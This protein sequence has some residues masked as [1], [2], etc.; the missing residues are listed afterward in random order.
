M[1]VLIVNPLDWVVSVVAGTVDASTVE[2]VTLTGVL[3]VPELTVITTS[4]LASEIAVPCPCAS[5]GV[6]LMPPAL[7]LK[8]KETVFPLSGFPLG[9]NIL[10][11]TSDASVPPIP[12]KEMLPGVA[13]TN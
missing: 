6:S 10:K 12:F 4:P 9:S 2:A 11:V 7:V 3:T 1:P 8:S 5:D 13:E